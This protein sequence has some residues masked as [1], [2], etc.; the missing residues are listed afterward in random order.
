MDNVL[1]L[2]VDMSALAVVRSADMDWQ[3][4]PSANRVAQEALL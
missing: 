2:N 3:A 4:S 1:S